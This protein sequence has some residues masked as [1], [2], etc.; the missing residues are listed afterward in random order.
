M[1][2]CHVGP[3]YSKLMQW[4]LAFVDKLAT[5]VRAQV[6]KGLVILPK[7]EVQAADGGEL[8][9]PKQGGSQQG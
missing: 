3:G 1:L 7:S 2:L 8:V 4:Y 9:G 6:E 5:E